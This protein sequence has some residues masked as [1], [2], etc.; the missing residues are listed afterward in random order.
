VQ[1]KF[2]MV[3]STTYLP[4]I[5]VGPLAADAKGADASGGTPAPQ[6]EGRQKQKLGL[7]QP[8]V[9]S[10][11][12]SSVARIVNKTEARK[13]KEGQMGQTTRAQAQSSRKPRRAASQARLPV[14]EQPM[15]VKSSS[16]PVLPKLKLD[17][18]SL[19]K[20]AGKR[21]L[22]EEAAQPPTP[23]ENTKTEHSAGLGNT[24]LPAADAD[25]A[26]SGSGL[27]TKAASED[28]EAEAEALEQPQADSILVAP[29]KRGLS[30][31]GTRSFKR[32]DSHLIFE[33]RD[34]EQEAAPQ[35]ADA[36]GDD[37]PAPEQSEGQEAS[38]PSVDADAGAKSSRRSS[39]SSSE[40]DDFGSGT[41]S[42]NMKGWSKAKQAARLA[43]T[44]RPEN[45]LDTVQQWRKW[46]RKTD[47][48]FDA[49]P[50]TSSWRGAEA[51]ARSIR[52]LDEELSVDKD[53][54]RLMIQQGVHR[55]KNGLKLTVRHVQ[56][57]IDRETL[58]RNR[59]ETLEKVDTHGKRIQQALQDSLRARKDLRT[60]VQLLKETMTEKP[61]T[62]KKKPRVAAKE[63]KCSWS[64]GR[65]DTI[66]KKL[67][68]YIRTGSLSDYEEDRDE[69]AKNRK[70]LIT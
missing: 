45:M 16:T 27:E 6:P 15:P 32:M 35:E 9:L 43:A 36:Q 38:P 48:V 24:D 3:S 68:E 12:W 50:Q 25:I 70:S 37:L 59:R 64:S 2:A 18:E 42:M 54:L 33:P 4:P 60:C 69:A 31:K 55:S 34:T 22:E 7:T 10:T 8:H 62:D 56:P 11:S 1:Q 21:I 51:T 53:R 57:D 67:E 30:K 23:P 26:V 28:Q 46:C 66:K 52:D 17:S 39:G 61:D 49:A 29:W 47:Q 20:E 13:K 40:L 41:H 44:L 14:K 65:L 58:W 5:P 63:R 19:E